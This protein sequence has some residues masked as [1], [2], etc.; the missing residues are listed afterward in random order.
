MKINIEEVLDCWMCKERYDEI[1]DKTLLE[2]GIYKDYITHLYTP[3]AGN[4]YLSHRQIEIKE[5]FFLR[6]HWS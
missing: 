2:I 3:S 1:T 6:I 4:H 5:I